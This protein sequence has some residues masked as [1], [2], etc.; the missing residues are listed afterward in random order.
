MAENEQNNEQKDKGVAQAPAPRGLGKRQK[1][2]VQL[3]SRN[4]FLRGADPLQ[5]KEGV[6]DVRAYTNPALGDGV[7][8]NSYDEDGNVTSSQFF[9]KGKVHLVTAELA[10]SELFVRAD[11]KE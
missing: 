7:E 5:D 2:E 10:D 4:D 8:L 9:A 3:A 6:G 11:E 1:E